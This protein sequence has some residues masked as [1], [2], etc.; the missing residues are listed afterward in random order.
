MKE[1]FK[2][3]LIKSFNLEKELPQWLVLC[4]TLLLLKNKNTHEVKNYRPIALQ[5][6]M[7]NVS[8]AIITDFIIDHCTTNN[9]VTEKQA[10]GKL[11]SWGCADQLAINKMVYDEVIRNRR[12]LVTVWLDCKKAFDSV[13][14]SSII[15]SLKLA[16]IPDEILEVIKMLMCKWRVKIHLYG[17]TDSIETSEIKYYK[18]IIQGDMLSLILFILSVNQLS[19]ILHKEEGYKLGKKKE[20]GEHKQETEKTRTNLSHL[21][22]VDDIKL[23]GRT[24]EMMRTL[25]EIVTQFSHDVR[26]K[27]GED[28]CAYQCIKRRKIRN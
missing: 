3:N 19:F 20:Q 17:E 2:K 23:Y 14:H 5:N 25:L 22:F 1:H 13:P 28:K 9:I 26:M 6:S 15:K 21:F 16:K 4:K 12:N 18:G 27:F 8:T 10:A 11:E 24:L 7:Y